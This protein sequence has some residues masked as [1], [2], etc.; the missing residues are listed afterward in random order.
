MLVWA[1]RVSFTWLCTE[2]EIYWGKRIQ[3]YNCVRMQKNGEDV[4]H[5]WNHTFRTKKKWNG[6]V[7]SFVIAIVETRKKGLVILWM[8]PVLIL[9]HWMQVL[10]FSISNQLSRCNSILTFYC[11]AV[12]TWREKTTNTHKIARTQSVTDI[13]S[14]IAVH[15][16]NSICRW[17]KAKSF[18]LLLVFI[19]YLCCLNL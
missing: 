10:K 17:T 6:A 18:M 14:A 5:I 15:L 9:V 16:S 2:F 11:F 13:V 12:F 4:T 3:F 1:H 19:K 7:N 8:Y